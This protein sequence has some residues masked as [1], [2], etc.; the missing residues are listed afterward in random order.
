MPIYF[1]AVT[2]EYTHDTTVVLSDT[3]AAGNVYF[4][5]Y[6]D[7]QGKIREEWFFNEVLDPGSI[8]SA[9]IQMLTAHAEADY[10]QSV[11]AG[12]HI[13]LRLRIAN[14]LSRKLN[15]EFRFILLNRDGTDGP[16]ASTGRQII[17]FRQQDRTIDVP[18]NIAEACKKFEL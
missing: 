16:L 3:S 17:V 5:R 7:W 13:S 6:F 10:K 15:M 18:P 8:F 9:G 2:G 14:V 4:A 11:Y 1:H 12:Q